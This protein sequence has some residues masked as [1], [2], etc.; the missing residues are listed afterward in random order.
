MRSQLGEKKYPHVRGGIYVSGGIYLSAKLR[1]A[2][3]AMVTEL[4]VKHGMWPIAQEQ[5]QLVCRSCP[6]HG[7][8]LVVA[9]VLLDVTLRWQGPAE[10]YIKQGPTMWKTDDGLHDDHVGLTDCDHCAGGLAQAR[11]VEVHG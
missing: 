8:A 3:T 1:L 4:M 11:A 5:L 6:S 2:H 7:A 9:R 10:Q